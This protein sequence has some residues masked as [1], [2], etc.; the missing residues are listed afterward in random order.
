MINAYIIIAKTQR[1]GKRNVRDLSKNVVFYKKGKANPCV[2][3]ELKRPPAVETRGKRNVFLQKTLRFLNTQRAKNIN[4][5]P[6]LKTQRPNVAVF[7]YATCQ[8]HKR[9]ANPQNAT[10]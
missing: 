7:Q 2:F 6:I 5:R 4:A 9:K 3:N 1:S 8:K 10:S